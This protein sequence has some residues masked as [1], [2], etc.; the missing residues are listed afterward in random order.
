MPQVT[1]YSDYAQLGYPDDPDPFSPDYLSDW[2]VTLGLQLPLFTGGRIK[3]DVAVANANLRAGAARLQQ[4]RERAQVDARNADLQLAAAVAAWEASAGTEEQA[5]R[6]Y[7]I[8]E[9]RYREGL[10]T[11]TELN[12]LRIQLAQA[13]ATRA[14][15]ARDLQIARIRLALLPALPLDGDRGVPHRRVQPA[16]PARHNHRRTSRRPR[17]AG[18][19]RCSADQ[20]SGERCRHDKAATDL[21]V[22]RPGPRRLQK[23]G[24][25]DRHD[26]LRSRS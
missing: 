26:R 25:G 16:P 12:D 14:R 18:P 22:G 4:T 6:A 2:T 15:A 9:V 7:Q 13:Q 11:Q 1:L 19:A 10:S 17:P 8:A 21:R 24:G 5:G 23:R 20:C 3:G